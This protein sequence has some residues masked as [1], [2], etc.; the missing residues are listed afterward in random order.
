MSGIANP[1]STFRSDDVDVC[2]SC[3]FDEAVDASVALQR[4]L[5]EKGLTVFVGNSAE[6]IM[7][8]L[9]ACKLTVVMGTAS[10]GMET[11]AQFG[12][13]QELRYIVSKHKPFF[14]VKMCHAFV[15][16]ST[17][18]VLSNTSMQSFFWVPE[19]R[20][21]SAIVPPGLVDGIMEAFNVSALSPLHT[22]RQVN[23][24]QTHSHS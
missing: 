16:S 1:R 24:A 23:K 9:N 22:H 8:A 13:C 2:I 14:L 6:G 18:R 10:Y 12:T 21:A 11:G 5:Q 15:A 19:E 20:A 3:R 7:H 4:Q 17:A